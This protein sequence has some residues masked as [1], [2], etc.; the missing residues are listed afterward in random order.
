MLSDSNQETEEVLSLI[1]KVKKKAC[2]CNR[3]RIT[4]IEVPW[5]S[6]K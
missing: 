2:A 5:Q 6:F 1:K 3:T 4:N